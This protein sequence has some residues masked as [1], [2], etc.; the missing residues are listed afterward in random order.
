MRSKTTA[1]FRNLYAKLPAE[2]RQ[3]AKD[4]YKLFTANPSHPGLHFKKVS[5]TDPIY[6]ARV[7]LKYRVI[8]LLDKDKMTWF[9]V[10]IHAEY[11][12][13]LKAM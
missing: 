1:K 8:G 4:S 5:D 10:G 6:S 13:L 2:I 9:W 11:E 7:S 3:Q 12:R